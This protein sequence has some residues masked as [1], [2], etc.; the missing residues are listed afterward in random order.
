MVRY[1]LRKQ[2]WMGWQFG[3]LSV[4]RGLRIPREWDKAGEGK[5]RRITLT[6]LPLVLPFSVLPRK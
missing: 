5:G 4:P 2:L 1:I 6:Y 3:L